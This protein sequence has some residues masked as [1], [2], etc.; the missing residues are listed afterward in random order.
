MKLT[1]MAIVTG[2]LG[3]ILIVL[4]KREDLEITSEDHPIYSITKIDYYT[5]KSS[6]VSNSSEKS[7]ANAH[8]KT[9]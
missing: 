8:A 5:K 2:A 3:T 9:S 4:V 6:G 1:E 7:L